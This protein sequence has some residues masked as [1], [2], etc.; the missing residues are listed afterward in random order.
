MLMGGKIELVTHIGVETT[1]FFTVP[2]G[3]PKKLPEEKMQRKKTT[4]DHNDL[5]LELQGKRAILVN[6]MPLCCM[7]R[8]GGSF[9]DQPH[10]NHGGCECTVPE[11]LSCEGDGI[12][13][14]V[15]SYDLHIRKNLVV[16]PALKLPL[17][18]QDHFPAQSSSGRCTP[19]IAEVAF[20]E[21]LRK[22]LN[23]DVMLVDKHAFGK[24]S[25]VELGRFVLKCRLGA[26]STDRTAIPSSCTSCLQ[27]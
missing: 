8:A 11:K 23:C 7:V 24:G 16:L 3:V 18:T 27:A 17:N 5:I 22:G 21:A 19:T 15:T 25:G 12:A 4:N 13:P 14:R 9:G 6:G 1:F 2:F 26:K 20:V 10:N